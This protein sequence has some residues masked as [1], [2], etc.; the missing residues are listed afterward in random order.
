MENGEGVWMKPKISIN[1][2]GQTCTQRIALLLRPTGA[3]TKGK[4]NESWLNFEQSDSEVCQESQK[5]LI[6]TMTKFQKWVPAK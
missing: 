4:V 3:T 1:N 6:S 2:K 5:W